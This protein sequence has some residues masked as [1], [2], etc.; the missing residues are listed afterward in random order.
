MPSLCGEITVTRSMAT[1][2]AMLIV[3]VQISFVQ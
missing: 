3:E 1:D 2:A